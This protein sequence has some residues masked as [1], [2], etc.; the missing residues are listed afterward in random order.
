MFLSSP[1]NRY[2]NKKDR[3]KSGL[4]RNSEKELLVGFV[5]NFFADESGQAAAIGGFAFESI[6]GAFR[7]LESYAFENFSGDGL[8]GFDI[9][10][11]VLHDFLHYVSFCAFALYEIIATNHIILKEV[12]IFKSKK[13]IF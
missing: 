12:S 3:R 11:F 1:A 6:A 13:E 8:F 10:E 2:K 7:G 4:A 5:P 9:I